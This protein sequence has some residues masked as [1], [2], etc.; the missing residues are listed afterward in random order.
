MRPENRFKL[1]TLIAVLIISV[2]FPAYLIWG[3]DNGHAPG[4]EHLTG[5]STPPTA[6]ENY[7]GCPGQNKLLG[8]YDIDK[9]GLFDLCI[10]MWQE[11]EEMHV[12]LSKPDITGHCECEGY[13]W[14]DGDSQE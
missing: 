14:L 5:Y 11:H 3:H 4:I 13:L 12:I 9:D 8:Y 1:A 10:T 2:T 7:V 6:R